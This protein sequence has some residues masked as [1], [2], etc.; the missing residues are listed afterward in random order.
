M[1]QNKKNT[2]KQY[3]LADRTIPWF[4]IMLSIVA[5]ETSTLTLVS[6]PGLAYDTNLAFLQ[7]VLGYIVGRIAIS[8]FFIP[9]YFRGEMFTAYELIQRRFGSQLRLLTAGLFLI[10]RAAAEGVRVYAIAIVLSLV[11]GLNELTSVGVILSVTLLYTYNKGLPIVIW[12]DVAQVIIYFIGA[13]LAI[14]LLSHLCVGGVGAALQVAH[15]K[16]SIF[17]FSFSFHK[18]YTFWSGLIGGFFLTL[19]SHGADQLIVQRLLAA[20]NKAAAQIALITSGAAVLIQF[21]LFLMIGIMLW[22]YYHQVSPTISFARSDQIFPAFIHAHLSNGVAIFLVIAIVSAAMANLSAALNSLSSSSI[23]DFY[24]KLKPNASDS[25]KIFFSRAVTVFWALVLF[26]LALISRNG[27]RVLEVGLSIASVVY[28]GMLGVFL[29]G[30]F[31]R[32]VSEKAA[33]IGL[34]IGLIFNL[35]LWRCT[36]ISYV[37]FTPFGCLVTMVVALLISVFS[38]NVIFELEKEVM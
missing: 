26:G 19:G 12:S 3:F 32:N 38:Q 5:A 2:L 36:Q 20:K 10:A 30:M 35:Y 11:L 18:T 8:I 1:S 23:F 24:L 13:V 28:G 37:W 33:A 27:G 17:D 25:S 16:L 15:A 9:Q 22:V 21:A 6:V 29:L 4:A 7:L 14:V 31:T 34:I